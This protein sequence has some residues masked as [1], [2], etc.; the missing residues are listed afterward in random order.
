MQ[1][2][3]RI[4]GEVSGSVERVNELIGIL[5]VAA[6]EQS[7]GVEGVSKALVQLQGTTQ[8]TAAMVQQNAMSAGTFKEEAAALLKLVSRFRIEEAV[9]AAPR[10]PAMSAPLRRRTALPAASGEEWREF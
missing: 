5:A 6:R 1:D 3:G 4:I 7:A 10:A 9:V 8:A 2:T